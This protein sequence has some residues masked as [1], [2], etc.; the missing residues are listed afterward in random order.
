MKVKVVKGG[1]C[2][3]CLWYSERR[4]VLSGVGEEDALCAGSDW[5]G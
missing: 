3:C 5:G 2:G 1:K 4:Y